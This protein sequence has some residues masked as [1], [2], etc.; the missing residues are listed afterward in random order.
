MRLIVA[1]VLAVLAVP[2][3]AGGLCYR[4][5][6]GGLPPLYGGGFTPLDC[7]A[8]VFPAPR[9]CRC[10]APCGLDHPAAAS[11][12]PCLEEA[13][14]CGENAG[15]DR[16]A[17]VRGSGFAPELTC[18][19]PPTSIQNVSGLPQGLGRRSVAG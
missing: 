15:L 13:R 12:P 19:R 17:H 11:D 7:A 5:S 4:G 6:G 2:A 16:E 18:G 14:L 1:A 3:Y 8:T 9:W 10:G